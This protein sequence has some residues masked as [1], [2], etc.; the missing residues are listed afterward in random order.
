MLYLCNCVMKTEKME[1][2]I[3]ELLIP[4]TIGEIAVLILQHAIKLTSADYGSIFLY[5]DDTNKWKKI[6]STFPLQ[7]SQRIHETR[8]NKTILRKREYVVKQLRES[9]KS[10]ILLVPICA[11]S[12]L[13]SLLILYAGNDFSQK[14][15]NKINLYRGI[16]GL[17]II[18][19]TVR[20]EL[21]RATLIRD[22]F[23]AYASHELRTPLTSLN[24]YIQLLYN[25][26]ANLQTVEARWIKELF[27]E[28]NRLTH[29]VKDLLNVNRLKQGQLAFVFAEVDM[30][31][32]IGKVIRNIQIN[33]PDHAIV[34]RQTKSK[35]PFMVIGDH[36]RLLEMFIS[37]L[38]NLQ[39]RF[40]NTTSMVVLLSR[41][42]KYIRIM[43]KCSGNINGKVGFT[44]FIDS[45]TKNT[46]S[47]NF[48]TSLLLVKHSISSHRGK[49]RISPY[50]RGIQLTIVFPALQFIA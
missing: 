8:L 38:I 23:I 13:L 31:A 35:K 7:I 6:S 30:Q 21:Q 42:A 3:Q 50:Q 37:L 1:R 46:T 49:I 10:Q 29:L 11:Q 44:S 14:Q 17:A 39:Q 40:T 41:S 12:K 36:D 16:A 48:S 47:D 32:L 2:F 4:H 9:D 33:R 27:V 5:S 28:C 45:L 15:I 34:F 26:M 24:G 25:K 19:A 18:Y 43:I 20:E 22:Q